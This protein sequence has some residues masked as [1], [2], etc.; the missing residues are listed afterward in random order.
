MSDSAAKTDPKPLVR[1]SRSGGGAV[2][3]DGFPNLLEFAEEQN[4]SPAYGCRTGSCGACKVRLTEGEVVYAD[5]PF[6]A[7]ED[8]HVLLCCVRPASDVTIEL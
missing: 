2:W 5:E 6:H 3:N 4:L 7:P 1:F 8:G